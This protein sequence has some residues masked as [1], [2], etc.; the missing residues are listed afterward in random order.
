MKRLDINQFIRP[1]KE[2]LEELHALPPR[3]M[4]VEVCNQPTQAPEYW[5][6]LLNLAELE[7]IEHL[8][9]GLL[10]HLIEI[11]SQGN[12]FAKSRSGAKG[13]FQIM[14]YNQSGFIGDPLNPIEAAQYAAK[15]LQTL[16]S[17]FRNWREAL[18]AYNWGRQNVITYGIEKAPLETKNYVNKF[19]KRGINL[20]KQHSVNDVNMLDRVK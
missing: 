1:P 4:P 11:E 19:S 14:P 9:H 17:H 20:N 15:T 16:Y 7:Q 13:L 6:N 10:K 2:A 12:Q 18:A 8:P 3:N 5:Y